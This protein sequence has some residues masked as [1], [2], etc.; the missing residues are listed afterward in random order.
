M[1]APE[2]R[3]RDWGP[4]LRALGAVALVAAIAV[5]WRPLVAWFTGQ[6]AEKSTSTGAPAGSAAAPA[7]HDHGGQGAGP[8]AGQSASA[9][10]GAAS[11]PP[12]EL[13]AAAF[14]YAAAAFQAYE[15]ARALLARD[16]IE[17]L[18]ARATELSAALGA[19]ADAVRARPPASA[20]SA[21][22]AGVAAHLDRSAEIASRLGASP[23]L[24]AARRHFSALSQA[25]MALAGADPR[26]QEGW[27]VFECP[28]QD[29]FNRWFQRAPELANPY[30]G[31]GMLTCGGSSA[32]SAGAG[33]ASDHEFGQS[34]THE[35]GAIS[36]YTCSMHPSVR[37]AGPGQ[38][39][40]CGMTLTPVTYE[41]IESGVIRI[42]DARR[43]R[44][45]L[46]TAPVVRA[47]LGRAIRALGRVTYDET[48]LVDVTLKLDGYIE[49][50]HVE[51]TGQ[52]V[53]LGQVLFTLYS[54]ELYAAQ[55]ELLLAHQ[56]SVTPASPASQAL[57]RAAR[58][59]LELW[60]LSPA[61]IDRITTSGEP[62]Q[63]VP[64]LAPAS[65][66]VIE[67][68]VVQG[69]AIE[70]GQRLF[71]IAPLSKVWVQADVYEQD[72][73]HVKVGQKAEITFPYLPGKKYENKI[74]YIYPALEGMTRTAR[75]RIELPNQ[76]L[77]LKPDM[78]ADVR[79]HI[80][81]GERL[82]VPESAV[83]Y[84][85]PRRLV[86]VDLGDGRLEPREV[87]LG[88]HAEGAYEVLD[89]LSEG[90]RVVTGGNFLI[91]AES[92]IRSAADYWS[93]GA[94][95]GH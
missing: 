23:D 82:Q 15:A 17:G 51:T 31:P 1:N 8:S 22:V 72:L 27:H 43:R 65:G 14:E 85:G 90:E 81:A 79:L 39:P 64:F 71:R 5:F 32:W 47:P 84:T 75:V 74:A 94:H 13:D 93:G 25:L 80:D 3:A 20:A 86:F 61:Q 52:P 53:R 67:K 57:A 45:G 34:S 6:P 21:G 66:Y 69:A 46:E 77:A 48:A 29:G 55:Q 92:R 18:A 28:M 50:L 12:V 37:Q 40:I 36:H 91:A 56:K 9:A 4:L 44:I 2:N 87:T 68:D 10:A 7:A 19:A 95:A 33:H 30:M 54:P 62:L 83:I 11:L 24:P 70:A 26:L 63:S 35:P 59:R 49:K 88:L 60:G 41:E 16:T 38:C 58:K 76:E 78:Y 42:D 73:P 89:G